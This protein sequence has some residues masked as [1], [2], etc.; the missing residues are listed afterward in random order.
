MRRFATGRGRRS[1]GRYTSP[2]ALPGIMVTLHTNIH[3]YTYFI[4]YSRGKLPGTGHYSHVY[5][6]YTFRY[7][8]KSP[9][10]FVG[11]SECEKL[12]VEVKTVISKKK[13][14]VAWYKY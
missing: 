14:N 3:I 7:K 4:T 2:P 13:P 5:I 10:K 6:V 1:A 12:P 11:D 9:G 8:E